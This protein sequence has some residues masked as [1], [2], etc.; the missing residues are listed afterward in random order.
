MQ[1]P[2]SAFWAMNNNIVRVSAERDMRQLTLMVSATS[3]EAVQEIR[4]RLESE[5]GEVVKE[6][7]L[8]AKRDEEGVKTLKLLAGA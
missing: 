6:N 2:A 4:K 8:A 7:P 5:V 1:M 3:K